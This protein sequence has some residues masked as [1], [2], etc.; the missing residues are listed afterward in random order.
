MKTK[1]KEYICTGQTM[2]SLDGDG[3]QSIYGSVIS[4]LVRCRD[5]RYFGS[6]VRIGDTFVC[7]KHG[8]YV[9]ENGYCS[10]GKAK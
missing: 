5:C 6:K 10:D 4:E 2:I 9:P 3:R 1:K 7:N 8:I